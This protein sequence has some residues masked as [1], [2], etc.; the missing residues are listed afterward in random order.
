MR[1]ARAIAC[2][3]C[4]VA[5]LGPS[6][7]TAEACGGFFAPG[8]KPVPSLTH[9]QVL[10]IHDPVAG[11]EHFIRTVVFRKAA[12]PFGFV[13]PVPSR[14]E[15]AAV[16]KEPFQELRRSFDFL[17]THSAMG[18]G[19][20]VSVLE[21]KKVGSLDAFVLSAHDEHALSEWL[22]DHHLTSTKQTDAWLA[23]YVR[24]GFYYVALRYQPLADSTK[25][26]RLAAETLRI[27]FSTPVPFYP[28]L[29]PDH[30]DAHRE[31]RVVDLWVVSPEA[32]VPVALEAR[33][34]TRQW[35]RPFRAGRSFEHARERLT[36]ALGDDLARLL[37]AGD[38]GAQTFQDQKWS[39][40]G[41]GDVLF[42]PAKRHTS[43]PAE[44]AKLEP[45]L[46][47]LD[48]ELPSP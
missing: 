14:P 1:A 37:P 9:E 44:R 5:L 4:S 18:F 2:V 23:H 30:P 13:V 34:G 3:A 22:A 16:A 40:S 48:P 36:G 39:R 25:D 21:K 24:L 17:R 47:V 20:G 8:Q 10:L 33:N 45:L 43:T 35:V 41:F 12:S 29:E 19:G 32:V 28:Y 42:V 6:V 27:S 26:G 38:L 46:P 11:K 15:V 7:P 31:P